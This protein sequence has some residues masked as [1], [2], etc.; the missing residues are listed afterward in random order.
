ME[1]APPAAALEDHV[2]GTVE[3]Y[4][5]LIR[6][7]IRETSRGGIEMTATRLGGNQSLFIRWRADTGFDFIRSDG[8]CYYPS[9]NHLRGVRLSLLK[10]MQVNGP[11]TPLQRR[12]LGKLDACL[13]ANARNQPDGD[14]ALRQD[15]RPLRLHRIPQ[16]DLT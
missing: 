4:S 8:F 13:L 3:F 6:G 11:S 9:R 12:L 5:R 15:R 16:A 1:S 10:A 14:E 7:R 2:N